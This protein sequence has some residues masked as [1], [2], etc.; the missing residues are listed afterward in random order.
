MIRA[1]RPLLLITFAA[2]AFSTAAFAEEAPTSADYLT[3]AE[4]LKTWEWLRRHLGGKS[5]ELHFKGDRLEWIGLKGESRYTCSLHLDEQGRV[6]KAVFNKPMFKN[7]DL[8]KLAGFKHLQELTAWHNF[9]TLKKQEDNPYSGAGLTAFA[10]KSLASV[11][12]GGSL[13]DD[14]GVTAAAKTPNL[15]TLIIYHTRVTNAGL[16]S[17]QADNHIEYLRL[18]PQFSLRIDDAALKPLATMQALKH[19]E[20]NETRLTWDGG[21]HELVKLKDQ[22]QKLTF[23]QAWIEADDLNKLRAALPDVEIKFTPAPEKAMEQMRRRL[24]RRQER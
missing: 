3:E 13:F 10:G 16:Q 1:A 18:G 14:A 23:Q 8:A 19:L 11:N 6:V 22:L 7:E 9:D 2:A 17:L 24:A 21:L 20:I 12:F 4:D 15:K 5:E